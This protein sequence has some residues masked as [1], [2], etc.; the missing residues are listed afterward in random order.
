MEPLEFTLLSAK[1]SA[2][3]TMPCLATMEE[4]PATTTLIMGTQA[5]FAKYGWTRRSLTSR[6]R[7]T[8]QESTAGSLR[9][10]FRD[11][12]SAQS[13]GKHLLPHWWTYPVLRGRETAQESTAGSL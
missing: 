12:G 5:M 13:I 8:A 10:K 6:G 7:E 4:R 2:G 11:S 1:P 9:L 3:L